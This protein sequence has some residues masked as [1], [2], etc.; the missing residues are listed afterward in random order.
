MHV[1]LYQYLYI[2]YV[3]THTYPCIY[4]YIERERDITL[5]VLQED[6]AAGADLH[7]GRSIVLY[8]IV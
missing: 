7:A 8:Y 1:S 5:R 2:R 3:Y 6:V 4:I